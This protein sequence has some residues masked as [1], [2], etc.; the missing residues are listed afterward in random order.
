MSDATRWDESQFDDMS[1]HDNRVHALAIRAGEDGAGELDLDLDYILEWLRP[2]EST[3][4]FRLAPAI[5]TFRNVYD[6]RIEIDYAMPGAGLVPFSIDAISRHVDAQT[7]VTR[8]T[9]DID[10]PAGAITFGAAGFGQVLR[11][12]PVVRRSQHFDHHERRLLQT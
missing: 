5:L 8:W 10:W 1:W 9:I 11:A 12:A 6:L 4:A 7:A 3:F 2:T